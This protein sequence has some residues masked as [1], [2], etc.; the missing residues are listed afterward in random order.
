MKRKLFSAAL[1]TFALFLLMGAADATSQPAT[2]L[3][4]LEPEANSL[5]IQAPQA[6]LV[7]VQETANP[8][9]WFE[10]IQRYQQY[11]NYVESNANQY[12]EY[13]TSPTVQN[14]GG[15]NYV[16]LAGYAQSVY[17]GAV[18]YGDSWSVS[19]TAGGVTATAVSGQ[20]YMEVN[21]RYLYI[22]G[23]VQSIGGQIC[24]PDTV[25]AKAFSGLQSGDSFYDQEALFW[26]SRVIYRESGNQSLEG[27]MAVG[28]VILNRVA[29][30]EFPNT[31]E[32]VLAQKN[33]FSTYK[34]GALRET[35]PS[36]SSVIAA[37]LV[38]DGG[39]VE[40]TRGAT[41]F[42]SNANSWAAKNKRFIATF[43]SHN[44]YG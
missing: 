26:L 31:V 7:A 37:K 35:N 8:D 16:S 9:A 34:S 6:A 13:T 21:G 20:I 25:A 5:S 10:D 43:G 28:N 40:A 23:G 30:P 42:D 12:P 32:G 3:A 1:S 36:E 14:V 4:E 2:L 33:Q 11:V 38:L 44:F 18:V 24:V 27:Q 19:V 15:Y 39:V 17:P 22:P 29:S 41:F